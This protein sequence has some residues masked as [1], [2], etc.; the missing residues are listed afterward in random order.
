M[1]AVV[2]F[3]ARLRHEPVAH[4]IIDGRRRDKLL[5]LQLRRQIVQ[6]LPQQRQHLFHVKAEV[7]D[8]FPF[9]QTVILQIL[10]PAAKL[11]R[12]QAVVIAHGP[13]SIS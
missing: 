13:H 7:R 1:D 9:R 6:I 10:L 3:P 8:I 11:P 12:S 5:L 2:F 4:I